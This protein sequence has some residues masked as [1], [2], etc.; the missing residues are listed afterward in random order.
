MKK[1]VYIAAE[2][3]EQQE[4]T[5]HVRLLNGYGTPLEQVHQDHAIPAPETKR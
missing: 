4:K 5:I 2:V 3:I 1:I